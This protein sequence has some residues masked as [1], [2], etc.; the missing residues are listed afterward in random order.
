MRL[1][2]QHG[3]DVNARRDEGNSTPLHLASSW[4]LAGPVQLLIQHGADIN[5]RDKDDS[6]PLHLAAMSNTES[7]RLLIQHGADVNA[8]DKSNSTP[9]HLVS[10]L[11]KRRFARVCLLLEHGANAGA[12]DDMGRTPDEV[13]LSNSGRISP[14]IARLI[15]DHRNRAREIIVRGSRDVV[16]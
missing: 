15:S 5:A 9:L 11:W 2:I 3:A 13:A 4:I 12:K 14:E 8:R 10:S 1:L 16:P 7:M 6:T